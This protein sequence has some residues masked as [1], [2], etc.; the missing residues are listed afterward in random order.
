[1][2]QCYGTLAQLAPPLLKPQTS[3]KTQTQLAYDSRPLSHKNNGIRLLRFFKT[4]VITQRKKLSSVPYLY[5]VGK[6]F[7]KISEKPNA[8]CYPRYSGSMFY[9]K[10]VTFYQTTW[11]HIQDSI[12]H[13]NLPNFTFHENGNER[14]LLLLF[15]HP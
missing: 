11:Y 12:H 3:K 8:S 13:I 4:A 14:Q 5:A 7:I 6:T 1:M 15:V 2:A 10:S 9:E